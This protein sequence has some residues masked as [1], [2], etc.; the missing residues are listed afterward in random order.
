[1]TGLRGAS[2]AECRK[3]KD[4][5]ELHIKIIRVKHILRG[6]VMKMRTIY[7]K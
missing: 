7:L 2:R 4:E 5:A 3:Q 6:F 1:M